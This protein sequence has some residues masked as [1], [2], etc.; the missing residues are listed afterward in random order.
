MR[1]SSVLSPST[2]NRL[3]LEH[4]VKRRDL[5][6]LNRRQVQIICDR[7]HQFS[8]QVAVIFMLHSMQRANNSGALF[9]FRKACFPMVNFFFDSSI[10]L[11]KHNI[12]GADNGHDIGQH[13]TLDHF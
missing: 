3:G 2:T 8:R 7:I 1:P 5:V 6:D 9:A 11:T 12:L 13:V 4:R 10:H